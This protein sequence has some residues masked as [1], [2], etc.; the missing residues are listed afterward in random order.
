MPACYFC[1]QPADGAA[2]HVPPEVL[3]RGVDQSYKTPPIRTVPSCRTH[4]E[5]A[6]QHDEALAWMVADAAALRSPAAMDILQALLT[7]VNRRVHSDREFADTR[8]AYTGSRVLRDARDFDENGLP[9]APQFDE[10]YLRQ[11]E[12][13]LR[14]KWETFCFGIQK[15][16]AGLFFLA[17]G[18]PLG[19]SRAARLQIL[20]P[21]FK[22][23]GERI[24]LGGVDT[25]VTEHFSWLGA[26][27]PWQT[28][29]SGDPRVFLARL[30]RHRGSS[31]FGLDL[32]FFSA[33][34]VW[35]R[36]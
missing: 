13:S 18:E 24:S 19:I 6:S 14:R 4:N 5:G 9:V 33:V 16:A 28:I 20:A 27:P 23:V 10:N 32:T 1:G 22:Q 26:R 2:D 21:D 3:F 29:Q 35:I 17:V 30:A 12:E 11:A 31:S 15:I 25:S 36:G 8:L 7:P 34:R